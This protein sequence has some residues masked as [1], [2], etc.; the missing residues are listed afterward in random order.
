MPPPSA[1]LLARVRWAVDH[2]AHWCGVYW[3]EEFAFG[4]RVVNAAAV[5]LYLLQ[6]VETE[7]LTLDA[8]ASLMAGRSAG[9]PG[10]ATFQLD[11]AL[12]DEAVSFALGVR[13]D[14]RRALVAAEAA[15][16]W[17][18]KGQW[19][20]AYKAAEHAVT[21]EAHVARDT[22]YWHT[23]LYNLGQVLVDKGHVQPGPRLR[24][25]AQTSA[26]DPRARPQRRGRSK[27][28]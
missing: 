2:G 28:R 24:P 22:R 11:R 12:W 18:A 14:A 19:M 1:A 9:A 13:V 17:A 21:L 8:V 7:A 3:K 4:D 26:G 10:T 6:L 16:A 25:H 20:E 15:Y 27:R 23:L 5:P